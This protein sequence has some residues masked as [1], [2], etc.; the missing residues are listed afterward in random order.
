MANVLVVDDDPA[1]RD[2][3]VTVLGYCNHQMSQA[4]DGAEALIAVQK[5]QPELI[6]ADLLMPT[7][8]GFEFVRRLRELPQF[9]QTPV[10]FYT[11]S[12][13]ESE[14]RNLSRACG[15][16]HIISKPAEPEVIINTVN[17]VLGVVQ[18]LMLPPAI[19]EF[20][21]EHLSLLTSKL[22]QKADLAIPRLSAMIE[23]G[24]KFA[25]EPDPEQL[26]RNFTI[27]TR[28][29]IGAKY[30]VVC[31]LDLKTRQVRYWFANGLSP[32][33]VSQLKNQDIHTPIYDQVLKTKLPCRLRNESGRPMDIGFP[34]A[35][36]S[37]FSLLC[38]PILS[39]VN[40]FGW[41]C[42]VDKLGAAEFNEEDEGLSRILASQVGRIFEN[43]SLYEDVKIHARKLE[44][45][46]I[47]RQRVEA[48]LVESE[49]RYRRLVEFSPDGIVIVCDEH[50]VFCNQTAL[51]LFGVKDNADLLGK[52][53]YDFI[54]P[55]YQPMVRDRLRLLDSRESNTPMEQM[56]IQK[57]GTPFSAEVISTRFKYLDHDGVLAV[58]RDISVRKAVEDELTKS[59]ER[60]RELIETARD[61]IFTIS[62]DQVIQSLNPIFETI[63]GFP[64]DAWIGR[65]FPA[66]IHPD[67][68]AHAMEIFNRVIQGERPPSFELRL[69]TASH[70]FVN[71]EFT[72][73][74]QNNHQSIIGVMGIGRD[75]TDRKQLEIE[76]RQAQKMESIG[77]LAA[78]V[79]HDFNNL[80]TIIIGNTTLLMTKTR[81][82]DT[83][84]SF[85]KEINNAADRAANLTRQLLLFSR[86]QAP[87]LK[88]LNLNE[89]IANLAKMLHRIVGEDIEM[90]F[91]YG[92]DLP[93]IR[94][95]P[96]MIEQI[97]MNLIVNARDAMSDGGK[98]II[99]TSFSKITSIRDTHH[100]HGFESYNGDFIKLTVRDSGC[101]IA[102]E[103]LPRI[104][105]P[106]YTTK[107]V[108]KGTGLGLAT[109]YGI[110]RQ[111]RGW[112]EV[113]SK[114][115]EGTTF[116]IYLPASE[117]SSPAQKAQ[118]NLMG[119]DLA[120]V[121]HETILMVE[122]D[123]G[124]S[125]MVK[126]VLEEQG[127][128]VLAARTGNEA[129]DV[130]KS[131]SGRIDLLLTDIVMPG[132]MN[133]YDLAKKLQSENPH[134][135]IILCSGYNLGIRDGI[136]SL[137][138]GYDFLQK[139]YTPG[140]L[141]QTLRL[142]LDEDQS[143]GLA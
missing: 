51:E 55:D 11:A 125:V 80:L 30:S 131:H 92:S 39:L 52:S 43:G 91:I 140:H 141:L 69:Q 75:V 119:D 40:V 4:V 96:G 113:S 31:V 68:L 98:L 81:G 118:F 27:D 1:A 60:Y 36:P 29:I 58:I 26:L 132:G 122:D 13:I 50:F 129:L 41:I 130:W 88:N 9:Q 76:L 102:P 66:L 124:L 18:A 46:I 89:L 142:R 22:A 116:I 35:Y 117:E 42:L 87:Q 114:I 74:P 7:M 37:V 57:D 62:L 106:F 90:E 32:E 47:E 49:D 123:P 16:S 34:A 112:I 64:R 73:T 121:G 85:L 101:G 111:H 133:G 143:K 84:S 44:Q 67:D 82:Y 128:E 100:K 48:K 8:D 120:L 95:D 93:L 115:G 94:A 59:D 65:E 24:L 97:V 78:G 54:H 3:V 53:I 45:E 107:E 10:I 77:Q 33:I 108:G 138:E 38:A 99:A 103:I 79:A 20:Q 127:Y 23:L 14:V 86:K 126:M 15:V 2:L 104:F 110:V 6:I 5:Q 19:G 25:T 56:L 17:T 109:V 28:K 105:D 63:T 71:I 136:P 135:R 134:L 21:R 72:V 139:P 137:Q 61:I 70:E 12:Y 83:F